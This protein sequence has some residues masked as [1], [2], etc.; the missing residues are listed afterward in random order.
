MSKQKSIEIGLSEVTLDYI[1]TQEMKRVAEGI[2]L[3]NMWLRAAGGVEIYKFVKIDGIIIKIGDIISVNIIGDKKEKHYARVVHVI[4]TKDI[5]VHVG[6]QWFYKKSD[7]RGEEKCRIIK[8]EML[9]SNHFDCVDIRTTNYVKG[10]PDKKIMGLYDK[11]EKKVYRCTPEG[12]SIAEFNKLLDVIFKI[13]HNSPIRKNGQFYW[14]KIEGYLREKTK[15]RKKN[16][17]SEEK[18]KKQK[19][20]I[21]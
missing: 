11:D 19:N 1:K 15:K 7:L 9:L 14:S 4:K 10:E 17:S 16:S 12:N 20:A 18:K 2:E 3:P 8:D 13:S 21:K 5:P 6:I